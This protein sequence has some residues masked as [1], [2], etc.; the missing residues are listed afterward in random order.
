MIPAE[1]AGHAERQFGAAGRD[2]IHSL[3]ALI[4]D[5]ERRWSIVTGGPIGTGVMSIVLSAETVP[6][7]RKVALK[8]TF[9]DVENR[10][11]AAA[12]RVYDGDGAARLLEADEERGALLL[13]WLDPEWSLIGL[14]ELE[15]CRIA[16][17]L[18]LRLWKPA[19][20]G[21]AFD[22]LDDVAERWAGELVARNEGF[23]HP[24]TPRVVAEAVELLPWLV[25]TSPPPRL[26]HRDLHHGNVLAGRRE[27]WLV[28]DPKPIVGDP[29]FDLAAMLRGRLEESAEGMERRFRVLCAETGLDPVRVRGWGLAK[30]I[31]WGLGR[32]EHSRWELAMAEAIA[33][34]R[35]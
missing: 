2:W 20:P 13:E 9:L 18:A 27:P 21:V 25:E 30:T 11:E 33:G 12:L 4:H 8:L 1:F 24:V 15:A 6:A 14:E 29:A 23:G 34:L 7:M 35:P 10:L 22:Q 28:I 3:P 5:L 16:S 17:R 19:L 31:A 32:G 26:L